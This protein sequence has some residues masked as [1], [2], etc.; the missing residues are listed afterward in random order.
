M[1]VILA[2]DEER[3]VWMQAES[4]LTWRLCD[5]LDAV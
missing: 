2:T 3:D 4:E 5:W 1:P